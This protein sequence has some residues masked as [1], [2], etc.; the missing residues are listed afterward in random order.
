VI[1][2]GATAELANISAWRNSCTQVLEMD[3]SLAVLAASASARSKEKFE[4]KICLALVFRHAN[5]P[6]KADSGISRICRARPR[7]LSDAKAE[8]RCAHFTV[9]CVPSSRSLQARLFYLG[10][11]SGRLHAQKLGGSINTFDFPG[12]LLQNSKKVLALA[13]SHFGFS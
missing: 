12:G 8:A 7:P 1:A 13:A 9:L 3:R 10:D 6:G 5:A 4:A 2:W 11:Q